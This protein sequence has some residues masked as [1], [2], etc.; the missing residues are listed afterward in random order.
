MVLNES[1]NEEVAMVVTVAQAQIERDAGAPTRF[2]QEFGLELRFQKWIG[3]SLI[4][5]D[6]RSS[7]A[8]L[9]DERRRIV[10]APPGPILAE[11]SGQRFLSPRTADR[12]GD[13]REGRHRFVAVG[14]L[15]RDGE[16]AVAAHRMSEDAGSRW[17]DGES[18]CNLLRQFLCDV[19]VHA[20]AA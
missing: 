19:R 8:A 17:I 20:I 4:D 6:G 1:R 14:M 7:P 3:R 2:A 9:F 5:Q 10:I 11:I 13:R 12:R 16:R 15:E 18:G